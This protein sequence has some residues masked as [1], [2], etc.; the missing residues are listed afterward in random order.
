MPS[1]AG[2][3]ER[4][5]SVSF[6]ATATGVTDPA[7]I[8]QV[9]LYVNGDYVGSDSRAPYAVSVPT[10][11]R[12]GRVTLRWAIYDT[13]GNQTNLTRTITVDNKAP[14]VAITKAPK[15]KAKVK[16]TVTVAVSAK[17]TVVVLAIGVQPV[18]GVAD[19]RRRQT[20]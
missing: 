16:G 18:P 5:A 9:D 11:R 4:H 8:H 6:T 13:V 7:G 2:S 19:A 15:N 20:L 1:F 3:R 10:G 12:N 17:D 14:T